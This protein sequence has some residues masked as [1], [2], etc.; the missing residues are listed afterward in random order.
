M[1]GERRVASVARITCVRGDLTAESTDAIVNAANETLRGG[2]GV[3]GAIH[4]AAGPELLAE[5]VRRYPDGCP[6]GEA[7]ITAG[8]RLAA[9]W[10]IH[11]VGPIYRDGAH[12]EPELLAACH[13]N[14]IALAANHGLRSVAFPAISAGA[15]GYPWADAAAV[16]LRALATALDAHPGVAQVRVVLF[17]DE[18]RSIYDEALAHL[19]RG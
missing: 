6:T 4:E 18:L 1:S 5:C 15:F 8:H 17:N 12:G 16:S 19:A 11:T 13:H 7:R 10:V 14:S 2:G 9:A 3:D